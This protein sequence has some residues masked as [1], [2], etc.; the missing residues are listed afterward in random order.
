MQTL[1]QSLDSLEN[2][3]GAEPTSMKYQAALRDQVP[4]CSP[5]ISAVR[6]FFRCLL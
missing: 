2:D 4:Y 5:P 6:L 1:V 3:A